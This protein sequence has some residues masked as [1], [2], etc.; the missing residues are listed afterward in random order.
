MTL[1]VTH[2]YNSTVAEGVGSGTPGGLVGPTE[3]NANHTLTGLATVAQGGTGVGSF[4]ANAVLFGGAT[5]G[6]DSNFTYAGA[7]GQVLLGGAGS[8]ATPSLA[9]GVTG[10][11]LYSVSTTGFGFS[12]NGVDKLDFG[13]TNSNAWNAGSD[14]TFRPSIGRIDAVTLGIAPSGQIPGNVIGTIFSNT[15]QTAIVLSPAP[16]VNISG[17]VT[18]TGLFV[19]NTTDTNTGTPTNYEAGLLDWTTTANTLTIGTIKGGTG[20]GRNVVLVTNGTA[21]LTLTSG[22]G[23]QVGSPTGGDKGAGTINASGTIY[24]NGS[25]LGSTTNP[26]VQTFLSGSGTYTTPAGVKWIEVRAIAGGG[27]GGGSG[28]SQSGGLGGTGGNTTFG[29]SLI[30]ANGGVGGS[31]MAA[32]TGGTASVAGAATAVQVV[33][34]GDGAAPP[35]NGASNAGAS[36]GSSALGGAGAGEVGGQNGVPTTGKT[37]TGGGGGARSSTGTIQGGGGGGAG[38]FVYAIITAPSAT[39]SYAVGAAGTAGAAGTGG[40]AGAAGGSGGIWVVE[41]YEA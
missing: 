12:V 2:A 3:W 18:A 36:G 8:A 35:S 5:I 17:G 37:N 41:H 10:T 22:G 40:T 23:V 26:T 33:S 11:G 9:V 13:I 20:T 28:S 27:G 39:Y 30:T 7:G 31:G 34:G 38:G 21:V 4:T 6:G 14:I 15:A 29:T 32:G 1:V 16:K 25:A 24:V 19:Y